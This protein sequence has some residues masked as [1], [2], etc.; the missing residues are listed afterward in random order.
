MSVT[1]RN[2]M[3]SFPPDFFCPL[4]STSFAVHFN[5]VH[6]AVFIANVLIVWYLVRVLL[7]NHREK[8]ARLAARQAAAQ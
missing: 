2:G 6:V 7:A 5:G 8:M 4:R 1:G 3:R